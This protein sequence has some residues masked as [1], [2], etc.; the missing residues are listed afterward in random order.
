MQC[1][2]DLKLQT[3]KAIYDGR[4]NNRILWTTAALLTT[5]LTIPLSS[6]AEL[7]KV[8]NSSEQNSQATSPQTLQSQQALNVVKVGEYQSR[9]ENKADNQVIANIQLHELAGRQAATVY[10]RKIPVLTLTSLVANNTSKTGAANTSQTATNSN[11]TKVATTGNLANTKQND[12]QAANAPVWRA[13]AIAARINQL[14]LEG[15][16]A[17]QI[18]VAWKAGGE[19]S[20]PKLPERYVIKIKEQ[21]LLEI[22]SESRLPDKTNNLGEDALQVTNRLRRLLGN[23]PALQKISGLPAPLPKAPKAPKI[24]QKVALGSVRLSLNGFASWYG[25]GF[26]GRRTAS[27]EVYNQNGLTAAHRN[28]PFGTKVRVTNK[29]NGR[30]V[31]VRITDRGPFVRGRIIDL[32]AAAARMVGVVSTGTAPVRVEVLGR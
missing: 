18:T 17:N 3:N 1:P 9:T 30:S 32:S 19:N 12:Y 8:D 26:H 13:T 28:L 5:A 23:A 27:G 10:V 31:I 16:D 14:S 25:P 24:P 4:M 2:H 15:V 7:T 22:N 6:H 29:R 11:Q 20:S 21:E